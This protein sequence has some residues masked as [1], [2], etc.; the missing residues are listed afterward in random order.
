MS[1]LA[2]MDEE[3][4]R[5]GAE[6]GQRNAYN[7]ALHIGTK[8]IENVEMAKRK[9]AVSSRKATAAQ[10]REESV[11]GLP[12]RLFCLFRIHR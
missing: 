10:L 11:K 12:W 4:S 1:G 2:R 3:I 9:W 6:A 7:V 8:E 5:E